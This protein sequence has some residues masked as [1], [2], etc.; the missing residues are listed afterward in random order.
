MTYHRKCPCCGWVDP[1]AWHGSRFNP[2]YELGD[3]QEWSVAYPDV[4]QQ[5]N[6]FNH[7]IKDGDYIYWREK[8]AAHR[9]LRVPY[10]I[11]KA[12]G[13]RIRPKA[14]YLETPTN[15]KEQPK[16]PFLWSQY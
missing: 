16:H 13:D 2:D 5:M 15:K 10:T 7:P 3:Y 14:T 11:F 6:D 12:N 4:A 1:V 9:I 8:S